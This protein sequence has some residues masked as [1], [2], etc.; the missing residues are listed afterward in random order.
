VADEQETVVAMVVLRP[1]SGR[2]VTG[3]PGITKET[4]H[5]FAPDRGDAEAV[6]RTLAGAGFEVGPMV[7]IAMSIAAPR[8]RF[9]E[10][11]GTEIAEAEDGGWVVAGAGRELPL[12]TL[13]GD[14]RERVHAVTFEPPAEAVGP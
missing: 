7:G 8:A 14:V 13:P 11:F 9:E 12:G 3:A 1:A 4:L 10:V 5:E 6:G 2:A